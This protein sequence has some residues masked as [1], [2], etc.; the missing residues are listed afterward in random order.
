MTKHCI[1][2]KTNLTTD[3]SKEYNKDGKILF[4]RDT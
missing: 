4:T 3:P 1:G 2:T